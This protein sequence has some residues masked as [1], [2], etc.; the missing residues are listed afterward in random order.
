MA[1][2][3]L[4]PVIFLFNIGLIHIY[5]AEETEGR[6]HSGNASETYTFSPS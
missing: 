1:V 4:A 2:D 6:A 3:D 5:E